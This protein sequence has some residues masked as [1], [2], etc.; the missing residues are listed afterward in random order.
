MARWNRHC[1]RRAAALAIALT[2]SSG[3]VACQRNRPPRFSVVVPKT[4]R[5][6]PHRW[7]GSAVALD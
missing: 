2:L 6:G 1:H 7:P 5:A 4:R 3:M